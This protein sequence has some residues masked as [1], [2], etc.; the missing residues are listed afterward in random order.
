M[1]VACHS[2]N[3]DKDKVNGIFSEKI[4]MLKFETKFR[5]LWMS[6]QTAMHGVIIWKHTKCEPGFLQLN[7][8]C[9]NSL[10]WITTFYNLMMLKIFSFT[11]D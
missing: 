6:N 7:F 10:Q 9:N 2:F 11:V 8:C 5:F 3:N 4:K 1:L